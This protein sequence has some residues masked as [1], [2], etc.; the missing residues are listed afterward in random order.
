MSDLQL[1]IPF[2]T[3]ASSFFDLPLDEAGD[4]CDDVKID[5]EILDEVPLDSAEWLA[6]DQRKWVLESASLSVEQIEWLE[7]HIDAHHTRVLPD[8][9]D[10]EEGFWMVCEDGIFGTGEDKEGGRAIQ[11]LAW[12]DIL[13]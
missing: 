7:T 6:V 9:E 13:P 3:L 1:G 8:L 11:V 2:E 4:F 12:E 5:H 10:C